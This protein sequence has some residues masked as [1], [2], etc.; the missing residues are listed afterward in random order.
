M[1][2]VD[3][4]SKIAIKQIPNSTES[5]RIYVKQYHEDTVQIQLIPPENVDVFV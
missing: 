3:R 2:E 1:I 4:I 5:T